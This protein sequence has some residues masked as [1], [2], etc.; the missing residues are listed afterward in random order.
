MSWS[1]LGFFTVA[2]LVGV[3][4]F[5]SLMESAISELSRLSLKVLAERE[6]NTKVRLLSE[7]A[8]DRSRFLLPLQFSSQLLLVGIAVLSSFVFWNLKLA[9][10]P[11]WAIGTTV[12]IVFLFR[13]LLPG[14]ISQSNPEAVLLFLL[15]LFKNFYQVLLWVS[16]PVLAL[17]RALRTSREKRQQPG[18]VDDE[19]S[20]EEI[21]AFLGVGE[22]EGIIEEDESELIQS[23]LEF[24]DTV[25][26]AIMTPRTEMVAIKEDSTISELK[27][28]IVS[29]KFS[30]IPVYRE[31]IDQVVGVV[32][33]RNLLGHLGQGTEQQPIAGL[34]N[35]ALFVPETKRVSELLKEM[36][37]NAEHMAIV[38]NE[39]G[40]VAGLVTMEDLIE[41]I[42][43][44]IRDEDEQ[45]ELDLVS[46]GEDGYI[47]RGG[48]E[49]DEVEEA[50]HVNLGATDAATVSGLIVAHLGKVPPA[51][52]MIVLNGL[53]VEIL[54]SDRKR[55]QT[56][57]VR[58]LDG[59]EKVIEPQSQT[60]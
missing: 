48:A 42:V 7:L 4:F 58:K 24:G 33:V 52:E 28:L 6:K 37:S 25:V 2:A 26:R 56:M 31:R 9:W 35:R 18:A 29:R 27:D 53:Q 47:V 57:R 44:E 22:E 3:L 11:L 15:P 32:Y 46:Y 40:S 20:E 12:S 38:V 45:E 19:A 17:L 43:G 5:L 49:I 14:M 34:I 36:Q 55:I 16:S 41:E 23:A 60:D 39:Y 30:R 50:L 1:S 54:T 59:Q 10:A 51:G 21:Q 8:Q 13:Q